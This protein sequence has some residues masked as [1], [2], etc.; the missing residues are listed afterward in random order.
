[1]PIH[2]FAIVGFVGNSAM[3]PTIVVPVA[4]PPKR[5]C[6]ISPTYRNESNNREGCFCGETGG[7]LRI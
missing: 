6:R 3:N 4:A 1:V 2:P 7:G 5:G